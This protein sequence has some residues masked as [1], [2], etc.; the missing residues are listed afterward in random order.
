MTN[1]N[2]RIYT[3][4]LRG[5]GPVLWWR[6]SGI[7]HNPEEIR[8]VAERKHD[9][10]KASMVAA[11]YFGWMHGWGYLGRERSVYGDVLD[12]YKSARGYVIVIH[13]QRFELLAPADAG[14]TL[15]RLPEPWVQ[16]EPWE[17]PYEGY[18]VRW[19]KP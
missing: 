10:E 3:H 15:D 7:G 18:V 9:P 4:R 1:T 8:Q 5:T 13:T 12:Y 14:V 11:I 16:A 6:E 2:G 17:Q 19:A